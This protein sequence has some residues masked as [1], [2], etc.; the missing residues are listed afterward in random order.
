MSKRLI[1]TALKHFS[2]KHGRFNRA[3]LKL[4]NLNSYEYADFLKQ[5]NFLYR[6]GDNNSF[7]KGTNFTDPQLVS[8]GSNCIFSDC[9]LLCHDGTVGVL[10]SIYSEKFDSVG[11]I[12]V[13]DNVFI[14]HGA[15]VMPG[16]TIASNVIIAAGAVV[17]KDVQ[18][19]DIV[20]G[21]PARP[22]AKV[23]DFAN[24]VRLRMQDYPWL[25]LILQRQGAYDAAIES[26]LLKMRQD[27][28]Y[29]SK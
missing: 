6:Q 4:A 20:A 11:K 9:T 12:E 5:K 15:I 2:I 3:Y 25:P 22:I 8:I 24:K 28:F 10:N 19:G 29:N 7:N 17:T 14:G 23:D 13:G 1:L 21:V 27:Y 16:V 26:T 18:F